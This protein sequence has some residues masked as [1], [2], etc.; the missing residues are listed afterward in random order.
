[1]DVRVVGVSNAPNALLEYIVA[2]AMGATVMMRQELKD[3]V[4]S[5]ARD[6][7][8]SLLKKIVFYPDYPYILRTYIGTGLP[9]FPRSREQMA[10]ALHETYRM[11]FS[12]HRTSQSMADWDDLSP[13]LRES[14]LTAVDQIVQKFNEIGYCLELAEGF[15]IEPAELSIFEVETL[16]EMEHDR[17]VLKRLIDGWRYGEEKSYEN[18]TDPNLKNWVDLDDSVR[19]I[20][21]ML[22]R[23][24]PVFLSH[25]DIKLKKIDS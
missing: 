14:N 1:V 9:G 8:Y 6:P 25:F 24:L 4:P 2:I 23:K 17:W 20:D 11:S 7:L 3:D 19:D 12:Q 10:K 18:K 15:K 5:F 22:V 16:A 13:E 21:R